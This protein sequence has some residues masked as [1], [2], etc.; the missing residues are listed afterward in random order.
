MSRHISVLGELPADLGR[1]LRDAG[2]LVVPDKALVLVASGSPKDVARVVAE[3]RLPVAVGRTGPALVELVAAGAVLVLQPPFQ[4]NKLRRSLDPLVRVARLWKQRI[5]VQERR[6]MQAVSDLHSTQDLLGRL[7]D[8][9]PNPVMGADTQGRVLVYNRAAEQ[10][11]G[12]DAV[13]V[14]EHMHVSDIYADPGD[15]RRVLG[16]IRD[17]PDGV[18]HEI[19]VRLRA[20]TGEQLPVSLSAAE[21]YGQDGLPM[22]TVG[23]FQDRRI[24]FH[25]RSRLEETTEQLIQTEQR[26]AASEAIRSTAHELNQPLTAAM[27]SLELLSMSQQLD[28]KGQARVD[29]AYKQLERMAQVVRTMVRTTQRP[30]TQDSLSRRILDLSGD[31][32]V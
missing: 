1:A 27:G 2:F 14:R 29:R 23:I 26:A 13:W 9:T 22:A 18:V 5:D 6:T 8:A 24:E 32:D 21:V 25:L 3:Q 16:A 17:S 7:I 30:A 4:A 15:A 11:L 28:E 31:L 19:E 20:R 12:Y 10:A